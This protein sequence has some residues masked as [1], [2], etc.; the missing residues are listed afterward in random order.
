MKILH[1]GGYRPEIEVLVREQ[2]LAGCDVQVADISSTE[3]VYQTTELSGRISSRLDQLMQGDREVIHFHQLTEATYTANDNELIDSLRTLR[4]GGK[5]L[6]FSLGHKVLEDEQHVALLREITTT[7]AD[8]LFINHPGQ[9][10]M[11][12][13]FGI[14]DESISQLPHLVDFEQFAYRERPDYVDQPLRILLLADETNGSDELESS[15]KSTIAGIDHVH[16][17]KKSLTEFGTF[18][19]VR[20]L[21]MAADIIVDESTQG[22]YGPCSAIALTLGKTVVAPL[23][24]LEKKTSFTELKL[25]PVVNFARE[26]VA[27]RVQKL[28]REPKSLRDL[29]K[30]SR[31]YS[32]TYHSAAVQT[33]LTIEVYKQVLREG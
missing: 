22:Y 18:E 26:N 3:Q 4:E 20:T 10:S 11:L 2:K 31:L 19:D 30:R 16:F 29:C 12:S 23:G 15:I 17:M 25:S 5:K 14:D 6:V 24:D 7:I 8:H 28:I 27:E 13:L 1:F 9:S 32:E 33:P 21:F